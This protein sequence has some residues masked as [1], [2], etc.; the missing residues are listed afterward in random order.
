MITW[1][2]RI[3]KR[4]TD[5][6]IELE[7][8]RRKY[9]A[10]ENPPLEFPVR[11]S[12]FMKFESLFPEIREVDKTR[13]ATVSPEMAFKP[14]ETPMS[15]QFYN[16]F[17]RKPSVAP[18]VEPPVSEIPL[19]RKRPTPFLHLPPKR[20]PIKPP[21]L[22]EELAET[23]QMP[24]LTWLDKVRELEE[25]PVKLVPFVSSGVE[26]YTLGKLLKAAKDLEDGKE[27]SKEDLLGLKEYV[28]RSL[29]D[30]DW[31]YKVAD[32]VAQMVPFMGE[33]IA[34]GG[35]F[36]VGKTAAV[37]A[38]TV[39]LKKLATKTGAK[40][41]EGKLAQLGVEAVGTV[42][43]G[44]L[45][46]LATGTVRVPA[47]TIRK[48]LEATLTGDEESVF[49]SAKK[50]FGEHWVEIVSESTGGMFGV[51]SSPIKGQLVKIALFKAFLKANPTRRASDVSRVFNRMGYHGVL[52][53][54][55]EERIA[56][57]GHGILYPLG[58]SD[59]P[60]SIPSLEQLS[61]ELAAFS[62]PGAVAK[63]MEALP[64]GAVPGMAGV[65]EPEMPEV[66]HIRIGDL[67]EGGK[68]WNYSAGRFEKGISSYGARYD[69]TTRKYHI[70]PTEDN[71]DTLAELM[72]AIQSGKKKV[73]E[74]SGEE[75][76][77][78][79][80]AEPLLA[81]TARITKTISPDDVIIDTP[82][83]QTLSGKKIPKAE[84]GM[85]EAGYQPAMI[86]GVPEREVRPLG[87]GE[88]TQISMEDQLKLEEARRQA[89]EA[90]DEVREAYEAQAEIEGLKVTHQT[91]P[92]AQWRTEETV[93]RKTKQPDGTWKL[94]VGKRKVGLESFIS[95]KEQTFPE[96]FTLKQARQLMPGHTFPEYSQ[97]GTPKY[98]RVP[99]DVALDDISKA[100]G[101]T[102]DQI[103]DRVMAI[104]QE[105]RRIKEAQEIIKRQMTKKPLTPQTE[106]TT[107]E[108]Q[109][110]W[111]IVGRPKL[112]LKQAEAL[113]GFFGEYV[114]S[115][116][117][118]TAWELTRQLR[119]E[120]MAGRA[121][122]L[123]ARAQ[124]L[125][126]TQGLDAEAGMKQ[127]IKE[128]LSGELPTLST[129]YFQDMS[130][131]LR[132]AL[133]AMVFHNKE[134]QAHPLE[135]AST[136]TA[137]TN[138]LIGRPIPRERG[139]GTILFPEGGSAWDRLNYVF[140][141][142][143]KVLKAI[144]KMA[145]EK[146]PISEVVE[147]IYHETGRE[148][149]PVDEE[150]ADYL[151]K[152]K[153]DILYEPTIL[154][155]PIPVTRYEAPI[156]DAFKAM[157]L[158]PRPAKDKIVNVLK[159]L[160][161]SP[162]DIGNFLR[163]NKASVD[164]SFWRQQAPLIVAH[165]VSFVQANIEAWNALWSQKANEASWQRIT[166]DP[167]YQIYEECERQGGD[168]LRPVIL[169]S[170]TA[171]YKGTEEYGY[172]KGADRLIPKL[173]GKLP[174][175]KLSAR[176]FETGTN[177]HNWLIFKG[178]HKAM[179]NLSEQYASGQKKLKAGEALDITKEMVD[180]SKML[181]NFSGR[182]SLGKFKATA[183]EL[184]GLFFAPRY[185]VGRVM[186]VKDLL[187]ANPRVRSEAWK[188]AASFV[189]VFGGIVL[190]G[191]QMDWWEVETDPRSAE[192]MS[193]R[194][195]NTR[196]DPWGG[197]RQFLVFFTRAI[198]GSGVSS[199]TGAEYETDPIGLIQTFLRGKASPLASLI[200]DF[201]R[202]K[203]F[204][205]EEVDVAS[206]KQ[207]AER[208][209]P[210]AVWDIYEA[211][212]D[213]PKTAGQSAI[214]AIV[215][216]GVQTY[217]GDWKDNFTKLGLPK[218]SE[219]L[220]YGLTEPYYD[221]A[222]FW[223]DTSSQFKGVDPATLTEKKGYPSYI[224]AI[225]EGRL[226]K[227]HLATLPAV[228]LTSLNADPSK[229]L[230]FVDH[231]R[232]WKEREKLVAAGDEAELVKRELQPDGKYKEVTYKGED[233][234]K[235]FDSDERT[236]N[237]DRGNFSQRQ[238]SLLMEYHTIRDKKAQ[239][240]FLEKFKAEIGIDPRDEYLRLHPKENALL[241]VWGQANI[242]TVEAYDEFKKLNKE[243]DIPDN[244]V[245]EKV[246]PKM[247]TIP[248]RKTSGGLTNPFRK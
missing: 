202:G 224:K 229:G 105:K 85:P 220:V 116:N 108:V 159:E 178:Y 14:Y 61:V 209:S 4:Q 225:A 173:T 235:A 222:D 134:M 71:A 174:W 218:Y 228:K 99:R 117:A 231:Y 64:K 60:F 234:V 38:S 158:M 69:P 144:E 161:M 140:G 182:G 206:K 210:F 170:G 143:P 102:P 237:A 166:R 45:R 127:A 109:E 76:G 121:E 9:E 164:F 73:F 98:N 63:T 80:D 19:E 248:K 200:L 93:K 177:V 167:I 88:V 96:Y 198:N 217:T 199:V 201:W 128:S 172:Y 240:E 187:N 21:I 125:I 163:A 132:S 62:V 30:T 40:M 191:A 203:N 176:A 42:A 119:R 190:L 118:V 22:G 8:F 29:K 59:Q 41:L 156:E 157:P 77:K 97:L 65:M 139:T 31:G 55:L 112:T 23:P 12:A 171:Q 211:W 107:E 7:K 188:N 175:I 57:V 27:V 141:K 48:Q 11:E 185:A 181:A 219:N 37:K 24:K 148:P 196:I 243:F 168:F 2:E 110:N 155:E 189:S 16:P 92:V 135:M 138:A 17:R 154:L 75:V 233:A 18:P 142:R 130:N 227:E 216:A 83:P 13:R 120:T 152:L 193:I 186:S 241:A 78:G 74:I 66:T 133:F 79:M 32:V 160:G 146:K 44:T 124:E 36:A 126:V 70:T 147:G 153:S 245:S 137:L 25:D 244:A 72:D 39:A 49:D 50:A 129:E 212:M 47:G 207:W 82:I 94:T 223:S 10:E 242:M 51:L 67:P 184:S 106:L 151:R 89:E 46:A 150:T 192:Y 113:A 169:P 232:Q 84:I 165:P 195:G 205:G 136:V 230:T 238:F 54:M 183:P 226:V 15:A 122:I 53:E 56:E 208:V 6:Q 215:G 58:L 149:I 100:T 104:R 3:A 101:L 33:F 123:K 236:R 1:A 95:I 115:E 246:L 114:M 52:G 20:P 162:V 43:G 179:L 5:L 221:T 214:P 145:E 180:F 131:E 197:Y 86:E 194:I 28:D 26:I 34:T 239:K 87:R 68:S 90:P 213:D 247:P 35:I 81:P 91:D 204:V 111:E 103:A